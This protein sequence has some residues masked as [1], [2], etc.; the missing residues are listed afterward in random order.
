MIDVQLCPSTT[1]D[2]GL[3]DLIKLVDEHASKLSFRAR[4]HAILCMG[5]AERCFQVSDKSRAT[6]PESV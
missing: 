3:Y 4:V 5:I 6:K 2:P 1:E